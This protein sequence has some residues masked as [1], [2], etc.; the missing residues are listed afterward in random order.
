[1]FKR[2]FQYDKNGFLKNYYDL[3]YQLNKM[4]V[5]IVKLI[6]VKSNLFVC[7]FFLLLNLPLSLL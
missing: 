2:T 7:C 5:F 4:F 3:K 1:M 6:L